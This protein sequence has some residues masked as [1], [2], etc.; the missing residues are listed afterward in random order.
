M[1]AKIKK[2][3]NYLD[4]FSD[5]S[6]CSAQEYCDNDD[7]SKSLID[8]KKVEKVTNDLFELININND[9]EWI[10]RKVYMLFDEMQSIN[11][12]FSCINCKNFEH[13]KQYECT[14][15]ECN[16]ERAKTLLKFLG[17]IYDDI[18]IEMF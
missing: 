15:I 8:M 14:S 18:E 13:R 3:A 1:E 6:L 16:Y 12:T 4:D 2:L 17:E 9:K 11:G 5:C 10:A 7:C